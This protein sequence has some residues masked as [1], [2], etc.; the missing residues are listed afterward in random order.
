VAE[1]A[2]DG[3]RAAAIRFRA[4]LEAG[5]LRLVSLSHFPTGACGDASEMLG[6]YFFESGFGVWMYRS[7]RGLPSHAWIEQDGWIVDITSDQFDDVARPVIVTRDRTWHDRRF[8]STP[9]SRPASMD[10]FEG[11][12]VREQAEADYRTL[13]MRAEAL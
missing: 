4:A 7:C 1:Q 11:S 2:P 12:L 9:E 6:Q 13:K 8:P 3:V 5:G 10:W